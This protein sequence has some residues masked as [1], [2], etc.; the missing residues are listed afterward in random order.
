MDEVLFREVVGEAFE[1]LRYI[2]GEG[3]VHWR[4]GEVDRWGVDKVGNET[5]RRRSP[6][7]ADGSRTVADSLSMVANRS[8]ID[9]DE[10]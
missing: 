6:T 1:R 3:V 2:L 10:S 9:A 7:V 5:Y 4:W 8:P